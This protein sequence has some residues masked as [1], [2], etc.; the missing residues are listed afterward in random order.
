MNIHYQKLTI[1][2]F[3]ETDQRWEDVPSR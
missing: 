3:G 1:Q 2:S